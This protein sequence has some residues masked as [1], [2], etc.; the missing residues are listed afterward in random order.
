MTSTPTVPFP[1]PLDE[2]A[3]LAAL[4]RSAILDTPPEPVY[5][6]L[7]RLAAAICGTPVALVSFVDGRRQWHKARAGAQASLL[8]AELARG[9][10]FCA[11]TIALGAPLAVP[12][13]RT[14]ERFRALSV[15]TDGGLRA[16]AGAPIT[17]PDGHAVGTISVLDRVPRDFASEQLDAL[18]ALGRQAARALELR[19]HVALLEQEIEVR[20]AAEEA[21]HER[22]DQ[23]RLFVQHTPASVAMFDRELRY[24]VASDRWLR[25]TGLAREELEERSLPDTYPTMPARWQAAIEQVLAGGAEKADEDRW[26]HPDG[27]TYWLRWECRPWHTASGAIGGVV[28]FV[29]N[30]TERRQA[31]EALAQSE[32]RNRR[33]AE[34]T[35]D[36]VVIMQNLRVVEANHRFCE[37]FGIADGDAIGREITEFVP[38]EAR[39]GA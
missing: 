24:L 37:M 3:R 27:S 32:A 26:P 5:D 12:D 19:Q 36:G 8:G 25:I 1:L 11:H 20:A 29:E 30:V 23:L 18:A 31:A 9:D 4:D 13:A 10:A 17:S 33:L 39:D 21:L 6:D 14:D 34:A 22:E 38:P 2:A 15:V 35:L 16:Y 7:A 28:A